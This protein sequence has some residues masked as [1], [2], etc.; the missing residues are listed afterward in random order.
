[1]IDANTDV[2]R[3]KFKSGKSRCLIRRIIHH[4]YYYRYF[5]RPSFV[6]NSTL[7]SF[8]VSARDFIVKRDCSA[9]IRSPGMAPNIAEK[10]ALAS[11]LWSRTIGLPRFHS[12]VLLAFA[13]NRKKFI[14]FSL[15]CMN[16]EAFSGGT[17]P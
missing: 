6:V 4:C 16:P 8:F 9:D 5:D 3:H 1:M 10:E 13:E 15:R 11:R 14:E 17:L 12:G 7:R 2:Q